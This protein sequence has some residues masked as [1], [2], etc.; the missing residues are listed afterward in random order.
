[1][2][3]SRIRKPTFLLCSV[4]AVCVLLSGCFG[5][6][7]EMTGP[8]SPM[9]IIGPGDD[10]NIFVWHNPDLTT[11]VTVRPDGKV[12]M[13]LINDM[14]AAGKTPTHFGKDVEKVLAKYVQEPIVSVI[15]TGFV[16]PFDQQI[17]VV[18]EAF[19]PKSVPF[20]EH[21]TVLDLMIDVGGLT[22]YAA[23]NRTKLVRRVGSEQREYTVKLDD[24]LKDGDIDANVYVFPGDILIIPQSYF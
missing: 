9:Y 19:E 24:L 20:R 13:P 18:G 15:V 22:E 7:P 11:T 16:G 6:S 17:R 12:T 5:S 23:G 4:L 21:M 1:M 2:K 8:T 14:Q 10:L 3:C